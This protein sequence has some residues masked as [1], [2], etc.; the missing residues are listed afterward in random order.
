MLK[1]KKYFN[2]KIISLVIAVLFLFNSAVYGMDLPGNPFPDKLRVPVG[3]S[4]G[5]MLME[6]QKKGDKTMLEN[7]PKLAGE[8]GL[9]E[10]NSNGKI[11]SIQERF[12]QTYR[13]KRMDDE[14]IGHILWAVFNT[15][16][17]DGIKKAEA[18]NNEDTAFEITR[19]IQTLK[20]INPEIVD[21]YFIYFILDAAVIF[22]AEAKET[23]AL[24]NS[25]VRI[26]RKAGVGDYHIKAIFEAVITQSNPTELVRRLNNETVASNFV[27]LIETW[28]EVNKAVEDKD[29]KS[30]QRG[31]FS[32]QIVRVINGK[33]IASAFVVHETKNYYI[34]LSNSH[35]VENSEKVTLQT[36]KRQ[37]IGS[38]SVVMK[39]LDYGR[40]FSV[41]DIAILAIQKEGMPGKKLVPIKMLGFSQGEIA[42]L[43]SG[44]RDNLSSGYLFPLGDVVML[45]G[46]ESLGGD[47]GAPYLVERNGT[48]HAVA[49]NA[50]AS[51][52]GMLMPDTV[53]QDML[54]AL[55]NGDS[56]SFMKT[57]VEQAA[58]DAAIDY[59][60][61]VPTGVSDPVFPEYFEIEPSLY[62]KAVR[63]LG[64]KL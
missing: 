44:H 26:F 2:A 17:V 14:Y 63:D 61:N 55:N 38:A 52:I 18:L 51:A 57:N 58:V 15:R 62:I 54:A 41:R 40:S 12:K 6:M 64:M 10:H 7:V 16:G 60:T 39:N 1:F 19:L 53:K 27:S 49:I 28:K 9:E 35:V 29:S 43:V 5:R 50:T 3:D 11:F 22:Q 33:A 48:Y 56:H 34:L 42:T 8:A 36:N 23:A 25:I 59:L 47:S 4:Y 45:I 37:H 32:D 21:V 46:G 31:A 24:F 20:S 13:N 30:Q